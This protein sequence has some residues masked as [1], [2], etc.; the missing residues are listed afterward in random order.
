MKK[1]KYLLF[2][3]IIVAQ[4]SVVK[5]FSQAF[6][7]VAEKAKPAVVTIITDKMVSMNQFEDFGFFLSDTMRAK[8]TRNSYA[9]PKTPCKK[10]FQKKSFACRRL[11]FLS[12]L[13]KPKTY[14]GGTFHYSWY[15]LDDMGDEKGIILTK[16]SVLLLLLCI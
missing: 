8:L 4:N 1:I 10:S 6:A 13:R 2:L 5:Q 9:L 11:D 12:S 7:D 15:F 3:G 14:L 16:K